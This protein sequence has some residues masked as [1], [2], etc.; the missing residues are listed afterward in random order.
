[1]RVI[2]LLLVVLLVLCSA[3]RGHAGT[4]PSVADWPFVFNVYL[5]EGAIEGNTGFN[6]AGLDGPYGDFIRSIGPTSVFAEI[7]KC[8]DPL[9]YEYTD[10]LRFE[11][12]DC[13]IGI[14]RDADITAIFY[15]TPDGVPTEVTVVEGVGASSFSAVW[16]YIYD[17][18]W[19]GE[20]LVPRW[21]TH[22]GET[23]DLPAVPEP[24]TLGLVGFALVGLLLR[25]RA[26]Q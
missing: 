12:D 3:A 1:M 26:K 14:V 7:K 20:V 10:R 21:Q 25:P 22:Y 23:F 11:S 17:F 5:Q 16:R 19:E 15:Y 2:Q 4:T 8:Y 13:G 24:A 6:G 9:G 18:V